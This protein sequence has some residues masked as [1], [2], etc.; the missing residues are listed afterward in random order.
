MMKK[1][2]LNRCY[3]GFGLSDEACRLYLDKKGV[4]YK[5]TGKT[6][7]GH[8]Q[9]SFQDEDDFKQFSY[10]DLER[11]DPIL[12]EVIEELGE[13]ADGFAASLEIAEIPDNIEYTIEE[14][15]G[16]EWIAEKHRTW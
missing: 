11:D 6:I 3:G 7:L 16:D 15:D 10:Y 1:I 2:I 5:E 4:E 9:Y 14:Y 13:A 12:I 8:I